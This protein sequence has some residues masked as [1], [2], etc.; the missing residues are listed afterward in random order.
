MK[1]AALGWEWKAVI[2]GLDA[3]QQGEANFLGRRLL[4]RSQLTAHASQAVRAA[5]VWRYRRLYASSSDSVQA[6]NVVPRPFRHRVSRSTPT[7]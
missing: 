2:R 3:L 1:R 7:T 5:G 4:F 6:G